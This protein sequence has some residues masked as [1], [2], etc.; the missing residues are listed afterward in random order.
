MG[1]ESD[2][3][4]IQDWKERHEKEHERKDAAFWKKID[5]NTEDHTNFV[6][7]LERVETKLTIYTSLG[8]GVGSIMGSVIGALIVQFIKK[9]GN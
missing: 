3:A 9:A 2:L 4:V 7:A 6:R 5:Q 8:V 1:M